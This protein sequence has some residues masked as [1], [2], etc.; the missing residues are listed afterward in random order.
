MPLERWNDDDDSS[1]CGGQ[2][3]AAGNLRRYDP[4]ES[5]EPEFLEYHSA[6]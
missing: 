6:Q 5:S 2:T 4:T 1:S 3:P